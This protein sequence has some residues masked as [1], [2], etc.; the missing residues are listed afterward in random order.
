CLARYFQYLYVLIGG[1]IYSK[2]KV[3]VWGYYRLRYYVHWLPE[4]ESRRV[5]VVIIAWGIIYILI[6]LF[7]WLVATN[8]LNFLCMFWAL[9]WFVIVGIMHWLYRSYA[10]AELAK[11]G[12]D[13]SRFR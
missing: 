10:K 7:D 2:K 6:G 1:Y 12:V 11:R 9:G 3:G 5:G 13:V 8:Q 4:N